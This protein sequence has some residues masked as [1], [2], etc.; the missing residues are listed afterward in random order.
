MSGEINVYDVGYVQKAADGTITLL[1][2]KVNDG[3]WRAGEIMTRA[4]LTA[5][6]YNSPTPST[7]WTTKATTHGYI[8][9]SVTLPTCTKSADNLC[10]QGRNPAQYNQGLWPA[11][12]MMPT[13]DL[14][15]PQNAEIDIMEAYPTNTAF[16]V[17]TSA[18]HF[19]G[20]DPRCLGGDCKG[21]GLMLEQHRFPELAY[22]KPHTWGFEWEKDPKSAN[23]GYIMTGYIDNVKVWGPM[24]TDSLPADG[25]NAL[26]RG[27]NDPAGGFYLIV[28]LAVGGPYAGGINGQIQSASMKIH[29]VKYYEVNGTS[30]NPPTGDCNVPANISSSYTADKKNITLDWTAPSGG[31]A[32]Q[33]YQVKDWQKRVLWQGNQLTW[34][35]KSLPGTAGKFTYYFT[36]VCSGGKTSTDLQYDVNIPQVAQCN[37]PT[38]F[39][40]NYTAE[41]LSNHLC[42]P[43]ACSRDFVSSI[44]FRSRR[45]YFFTP[46]L[47][48]ALISITH[49]TRTTWFTYPHRRNI[50]KSLSKTT[51]FYFTITL[52]L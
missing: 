34:T 43:A 15:W 6:P 48:F 47:N 38:N 29:S 20:N 16:N 9:V 17:T 44:S 24:T 5:P 33:T 14:N 19:N 31:S 39:K 32:V 13:Y 4:N 10:Q 35:D 46:I 11:I 36:T 12:W 22:L 51:G 49:A 28:N 40:S 8:E 50:I 37:V 21:P 30:P 7:E 42:N 52:L 1:A 18:L 3:F 26:R 2:D 23:N 27:F 25:P 41:A 45:F